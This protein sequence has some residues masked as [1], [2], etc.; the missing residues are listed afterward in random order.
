MSGWINLPA[1]ET[2]DWT[3][4]DFLNQFVDAYNERYNLIMG[5]GGFPNFLTI[6]GGTAIV[7]TLNG[8]F[9]EGDDVAHINPPVSQTSIREI[10][11]RLETLAYYFGKP[12]L[13]PV[14]GTDYIDYLTPFAGLYD[15]PD[16]RAEAGIPTGGYTRKYPREIATTADPGSSGQRARHEV[17]GYMYDYTGGAWVLSSDQGSPADTVTDTGLMDAGDYIGPWIF[18]ELQAGIQALDTIRFPVRN[19]LVFPD[20]VYHHWGAYGSG[21]RVAELSPGV[22]DLVGMAAASHAT[23]TPTYAENYHSGSMDGNEIRYVRFLPDVIIGGVRYVGHNC[24]VELPDWA[25]GFSGFYHGGLTRSITKLYYYPGTNVAPGTG[26]SFHNFGT[27]LTHTWN[28]ITGDYDCELPATA[29]DWTASDQWPF[30]TVN[31]TVMPADPVASGGWP[32]TS[33]VSWDFQML[34]FDYTG[35]SCFAG[36]VQ[37]SGFDYP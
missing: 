7:E 30:P 25:L 20:L 19:T 26:A 2:T 36:Y 22:Y 28:D 35:R 29:E 12:S 24:R 1:D 33:Y 4:V 14:G 10:Q 11:T 27:S 37:Y 6:S 8:V 21:P 32:N 17:S 31:Q 16:W 3:Q 15:L 5:V 18:N 34:T 23:A 13:F 9:S